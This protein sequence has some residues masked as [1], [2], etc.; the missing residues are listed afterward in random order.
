MHEESTAKGERIFNAAF[1]RDFNKMLLRDL[2][3]AAFN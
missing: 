1:R 2:L 3:I